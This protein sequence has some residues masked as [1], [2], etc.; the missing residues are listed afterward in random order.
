[1]IGKIPNEELARE[2]AAIIN[3]ENEYKKMISHI[4]DFESSISKF[5]AAAAHV[6]TIIVETVGKIEDRGQEVLKYRQAVNSTTSKATP[7][8]ALSSFKAK[9]NSL[10]QD[11]KSHALA[12][13]AELKRRTQVNERTRCEIEGIRRE[14]EFMK[15]INDVEGYES[16]IKSAEER[17][18]RKGDAYEDALR[19][20]I[21]KLRAIQK[22]HPSVKADILRKFSSCQGAFFASAAGAFNGDLPALLSLAGL[23]ATRK[24][25][26]VEKK[27]LVDDAGVASVPS[28]SVRI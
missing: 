21:E 17:L 18:R 27:T 1:M 25:A 5:C 14:L 8:S 6:S 28:E 11:I 13:I 23:G 22:E 19:D 9:V 16:R 15:K 20:L 2:Y 4:S 24:D 10:R 12:D 7:H 3:I 26:G